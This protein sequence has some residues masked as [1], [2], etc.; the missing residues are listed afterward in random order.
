[1]ELMADLVAEDTF[2]LRPLQQPTLEKRARVTHSTVTALPT[3]GKVVL[4]LSAGQPLCRP[5]WLQD[6]CKPHPLRPASVPWAAADDPA[7]RARH[8]ASPSEPPVCSLW[9]RTDRIHEIEREFL[10]DMFSKAFPHRTPE[11]YVACRNAIFEAWRAAPPGTR[12]TYTH[13][14]RILGPQC[15]AASLLR[16]FRFLEQWGIINHRGQARPGPDRTPLAPRPPPEH[17]TSAGAM[18]EVFQLPPVAPHQVRYAPTTGSTDSSTHRTKGDAAPALGQSHFECWALGIDCS[19]LRYQCTRV[20]DLYLSPEAFAQGLF[21]HG[22]N[23]RDFVRVDTGRPPHPPPEDASL[24][25]VV[26]D[27]WTAEEVLMLLEAIERHQDDWE[28]IAAHVGKHRT[29]IDCLRKFI[30]LPIEEVLV[31]DMAASMGSGRRL[32]RMALEGDTHALESLPFASAGNPV[33]TLVAFLTTV[34]AP[35]VGAAAAQYALDVLGAETAALPRGAAVPRII[36]LRALAHALVAASVKA[37][38]LQFR[39]E[40]EMERLALRVVDVQM[41]KVEFKLQALER[42]DGACSGERQAVQAQYKLHMQQREQ[43]YALY[44]AAHEKL[45]AFQQQAGGS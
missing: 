30:Q 16:V 4:N 12:V 25:S 6:K 36:M 33:Q 15:D 5:D 19:Q 1:V 21:P 3:E 29:V 11:D 8:D 42:L 34:V 17:A 44:K 28:S 14:R 35:A 2:E 10:P 23:V 38:R 40:V 41:Q 24:L 26:R 9:F 32:L 13:C 27:G 43:K 20:P 7:G 22:T 31:D 45:Q 39:T 37:R 18:S